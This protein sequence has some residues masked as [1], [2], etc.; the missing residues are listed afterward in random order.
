MMNLWLG[1]RRQAQF[2]TR[3]V[4]GASGQVLSPNESD[5]G[6]REPPGSHPQLN[7]VA[8]ILGFLGGRVVRA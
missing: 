4:D 5:L 7:F 6:R 3:C 1:L 2:D 8:A